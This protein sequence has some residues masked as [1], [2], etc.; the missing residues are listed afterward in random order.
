MKTQKLPFHMFSCYTFDKS[1]GA[2]PPCY[3][4]WGWK[5][6]LCKFFS[7][8]H[9]FFHK[10]AHKEKL[11]NYKFEEIRPSTCYLKF[12]FFRSIVMIYSWGNS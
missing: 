1:K 9:C 10:S 6:I 7:K 5:L 4:G 2:G 3:G 12:S 8:H 11:V